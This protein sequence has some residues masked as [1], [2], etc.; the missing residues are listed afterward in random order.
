MSSHMTGSTLANRRPQVQAVLKHLI[1]KSQRTLLLDADLTDDDVKFI[2]N[3]V[4]Q[5]P[6]YKIH[7]TYR[8]Q[9]TVHRYQNK[10]NILGVIKDRLQGGEKVYIACNTKN[11]AKALE[12]ILSPLV[13]NNYFVVTSQEASTKEVKHHVIFGFCQPIKIGKNSQ[14][15]LPNYKCIYFYY[16]TKQRFSTH[17]R[18]TTIR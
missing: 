16:A 11:T 5:K 17:S 7:N 12:A 10:D 18:V 3:F 2:S 8:L 6:V 9:S 15:A 13:A 4:P 1:E 14:A